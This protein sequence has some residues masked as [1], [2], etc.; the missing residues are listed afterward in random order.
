MFYIS[1]SN[2]LLKDGHRQRMGES[3]WE[4]MW[5]LD[6]MTRIDGNG[7]GWVLGGKP[8]KLAE[9]ATDLGVH[10]STVSRSLSRLQEEGYVDVIH[11]P[12]GLVIRVCKARKVFG[13]RVGKT[14]AENTQRVGADATR[15]GDDAKPN[16]RQ[17]K[18][19]NSYSC[20]GNPDQHQPPM[21]V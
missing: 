20:S 13:D 4:F 5:L 9:L 2:G 21:G 11:A 8:I 1:V 7:Y 12:Y 15:F 10:R 16:I 3:V 19:K 17:F 14:P 18:D 6:H